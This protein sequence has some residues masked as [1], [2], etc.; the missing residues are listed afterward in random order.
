[1]T[2]TPRIAL[3]FVSAVALALASS[4]P[5]LAQGA[6]KDKMSS[7][8]EGSRKVVAETDKLVVTEIV[9]RPGQTGPMASRLG[10]VIYVITGGTFE[11]TFADG[12][13]EVTPRQDGETAA[14]TEKRPYSVRNIGMT[15]IRLIEIAPKQK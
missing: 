14:I 7:A 11:R 6:A 13:K 8:S 1:M 3:L 10:H 12:K 9:E 15:T 5:L 4:T 2:N